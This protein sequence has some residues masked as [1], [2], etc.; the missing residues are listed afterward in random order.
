MMANDRIHFSVQGYMFMG[1]LLFNAFLNS[2]DNHV[3]KHRKKL[4]SNKNL[5][6]ESN[7]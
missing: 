6:Q 5:L 3:I 2:Y 1:D 7:Q 4:L